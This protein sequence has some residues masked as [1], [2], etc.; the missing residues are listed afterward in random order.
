MEKVV[1]LKIKTIDKIIEIPFI[2]LE[3]VDLFT[4]RYNNRDELLFGLNNILNLSLDIK[5]IKEIYIYCEYVSR[6]NIFTSK[7]VPVKYRKDNFDIKT[8]GGFFAEYLKKDHNRIKTC[9]VKDI[10]SKAMYEFRFS[11]EDKLTDF[12]IEDAVRKYLTNAP[13]RTYRKVYF[14][15]KDFVKVNIN[16]VVREKVENNQRNLSEFDSN[17]EYLQYLLEYASRGEEETIRAMDELSRY[18]LEELSKNHGYSLED[19][20]D[21]EKYTGLKIGELTSYISSRVRRGYK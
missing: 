18:D 2:D 14:M 17:N 10:N 1:M 21:L 16:R 3:A 9:G 4:V 19:L 20:Y 8:L 11:E 13:Y 12:D 6:K 7:N 5:D 15:I